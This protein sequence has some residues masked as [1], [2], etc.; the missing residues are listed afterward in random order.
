MS[1]LREKTKVSL[2]CSWI[3]CDQNLPPSLSLSLSLPLSLSKK[4][5]LILSLSLS[6]FPKNSYKYETKLFS[7][8]STQN[9]LG[10][11]RPTLP[12]SIFFL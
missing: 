4:E 7:L 8:R 11:Q 10:L 12:F 6:L 5:R 9:A 1:I 3:E 2:L